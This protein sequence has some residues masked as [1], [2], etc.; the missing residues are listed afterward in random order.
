MCFLYQSNL[1]VVTADQETESLFTIRAF[2]FFDIVFNFRDVV[3][4]QIQLNK[5]YGKSLQDSLRRQD[6]N[7]SSYN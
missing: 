4:R 6:S 3:V 1:V 7:R 5:S 2:S